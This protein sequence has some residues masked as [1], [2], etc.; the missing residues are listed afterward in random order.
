MVWQCTSVLIQA[1][2]NRSLR[3]FFFIFNFISPF[4]FLSF[5]QS[6]LWEYTQEKKK[7]KDIIMLFLELKGWVW[8]AACWCCC[9]SI[10]CGY[11][12]YCFDVFLFFSFSP[13]LFICLS[14]LKLPSSFS[15]SVVRLLLFGH[16]IQL[17]VFTGVNK[18]FFFPL[19]FA[20]ANCLLLFLREFSFLISIRHF[21]RATTWSHPDIGLYQNFFWHFLFK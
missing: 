18:V 5:C 2:E 17:C 19:S 15:L 1:F 9:R 11:M 21:G 10:W 13:S 20:I 6:F 16:G 8:S 4:F 14:W 12:H 3:H 7:K